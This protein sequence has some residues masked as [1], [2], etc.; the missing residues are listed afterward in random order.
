MTIPLSLVCY[1]LV[2]TGYVIYPV[3]AMP[4]YTPA[5]RAGLFFVFCGLAAAALLSPLKNASLR[6][7][8]PDRDSLAPLLSCLLLLPLWA[9][10]MFLPIPTGED[11]QS[12]SS[13]GAW[14]LDRVSAISGL[15]HPAL[16]LLAWLALAAALLLLY[17][18]RERLRAPRPGLVLAATLP[19]LAAYFIL[20]SK[21]GL[22][23]RIGDWQSIY[24][25]PALSRCAYVAA[26][27]L[28]GIHEFLPRLMQ[29]ACVCGTGLLLSATAGLTGDRPSRPLFLLGTVLFP[30]FFWLSTTPDLEGGTILIFAA[31]TYFYARFAETGERDS[32]LRAL[33]MLTLGFFYRQFFVG[34]VLA[35]ALLS[36]AL[37]WREGPGERRA[38]HVDF[39]KWLWI[40]L[41]TGLPYILLSRSTGVKPDLDAAVF[42]DTSILMKNLVEMPQALGLPALLTSAA[43]LVYALAARRS[44]TVLTV[45]CVSLC[46][47]VMIGVTIGSGYVRHASPFYLGPAFFM[48]LGLNAA[49][50]LLR[51]AAVPAAAAF[52][53]LL[54]W[55]SLVTPHFQYRNL[56]N[57]Y[58]SVFPYDQAAAYAASSGHPRIYAPM[59]VEPSHFYLAKYGLS[60]RVTW[61]RGLPVP[62]TPEALRERFDSGGYDLLLLPGSPFKGKEEDFAGAAR[63]LAASGDFA[64]EREFDF[65]GNRLTLLRKNVRNSR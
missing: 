37:A 38:A 35:F 30:A 25:Y 22:A 11:E 58:D 26:Y 5:A 50:P 2:C 33:F 28:F 6:L 54:A 41:L 43:G 23:G 10:F 36:A 3:W 7:R 61:D 42:R 49:L 27:A 64:V 62:F 60:G 46:Y 9:P 4:A 39:L 65:H 12:H 55:R 18:F 13:A 15:P 52:L 24:E 34:Q 51:R 1:A 31:A 53:L 44:R 45:I 48:L 16:H 19:P 56:S 20:A 17:R 57:L 21:Y 14:A 59:E 8:V 29:A 40:P 63:A 47:Y 32:A